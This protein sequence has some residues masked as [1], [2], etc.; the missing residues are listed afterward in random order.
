MGCGALQQ[1]YMVVGGPQHN[2]SM[3]VDTT[4]M[5]ESAEETCAKSAR[6]F[7]KWLFLNGK[8]GL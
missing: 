5:P 6:E 4:R 2:K 7:P 8:Q 3:L 1:P